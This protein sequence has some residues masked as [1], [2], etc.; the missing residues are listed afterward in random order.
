[1]SKTLPVEA[2]LQFSI[3]V[4]NTS[5]YV[6][7]EKALA[8]VL[9]SDGPGAVVYEKAIVSGLIGT[10]DQSPFFP[11]FGEPRSQ[12]HRNNADLIQH[13]TVVPIPE[14]IIERGLNFVTYGSIRVSDLCI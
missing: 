12:N 8:I 4:L 7:Q 1:L 6:L 9:R 2:P 5:Q 13:I 14:R 3:D 10:L 11:P